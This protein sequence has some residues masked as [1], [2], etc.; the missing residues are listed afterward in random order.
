L[1]RSARRFLGATLCLFLRHQ[2]GDLTLDAVLQLRQ[3]ILL[4][5][6]VGLLRLERVLLLLDVGT[7]LLGRRFARCKVFLRA[8]QL[9]EQLVVLLRRGVGV[10]AA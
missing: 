8:G 5:L 10:L 1:R 6:E 9:V 4:R 7:H 3:L 2:L